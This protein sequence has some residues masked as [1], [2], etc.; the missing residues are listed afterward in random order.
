MQETSRASP[1]KAYTEPGFPSKNTI[2]RKNC[3]Y[4]SLRE[5]RCELY[6]IY[7]V[8]KAPFT[9]FCAAIHMQLMLQLLAYV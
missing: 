1:L 9:R 6:Q 5:E 4:I 3:M 8:R 7:S 2:A